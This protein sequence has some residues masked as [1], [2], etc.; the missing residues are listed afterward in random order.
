M[1]SQAVG[2]AL[3]PSAVATSDGYSVDV[4]QPW[5]TVIHLVHVAA[6]E[7][8]AAR[9]KL[10]LSGR[11]VHLIAFQTLNVS[12][13]YEGSLPADLLKSLRNQ[14]PES[15]NEFLSDFV[16]FVQA[17]VH[18]SETTKWTD[19]AALR[20]D[21]YRSRFLGLLNVTEAA[22]RGQGKAER[23]RFSVDVSGVSGSGLTL[24]Y[25]GDDIYRIELWGRTTCG[26][27]PVL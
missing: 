15:A 16:G 11:V 23:S 2:R 25:L 26:P 18:E 19:A 22:L 4:Q 5:P 8:G 1:N 17:R 12:V 10:D 7:G 21:R 6:P 13:T 27:L 3:G 20:E 14:S 24:R 9:W